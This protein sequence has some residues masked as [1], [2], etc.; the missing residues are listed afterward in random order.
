MK[1]LSAAL[2]A[3]IATAALGLPAGAFAQNTQDQS[4]HRS[5][6]Q[7]QQGSVTPDNPRG[8]MHQGDMRG[9]MRQGDMHQGDGMRHDDMHQGDMRHDHMH[10]DR[11]RHY[12]WHRHCW[13]QWRHH[14]RVRVCH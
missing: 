12:G 7:I 6:D 13:Y 2:A 4:M 14:H 1:I 10:R 8:D 3:A 9:D 11:G 5:N